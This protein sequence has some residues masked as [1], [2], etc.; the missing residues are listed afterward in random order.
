MQ[1][2]SKVNSAC[3]RKQAKFFAKKITKQG[4]GFSELFSNALAKGTI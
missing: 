1:I 3:H 2:W 4:I